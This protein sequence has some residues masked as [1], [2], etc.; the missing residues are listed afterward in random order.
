M[1]ETWK[2]IDGLGGRYQVSNLGRIRSMPN[3][4]HKSIIILS[5]P[6]NKNGYKQVCF[7]DGNIYVHKYVHR[8]VAVA[9]IPNPNGL[10]E[11]NH[12]DGNKANNRIDN[13]EWCTSS[14]NK[15]HYIASFYDIATD[16]RAKKVLCIETGII[17]PGV[18]YAE[19]AIG[20]SHG[21]IQRVLSGKNR[22]AGGY[23]WAY[24][25]K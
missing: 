17:Y 7:Y 12:K 13:L 18:K 5:V 21:S 25:E 4:A 2:D 8:L 10:P 9:F 19:R 24:A 15:R 6:T 1:K 3:R 16:A 11:V 23:H 20:K 22:T 14:W